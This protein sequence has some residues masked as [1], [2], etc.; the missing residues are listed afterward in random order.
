MSSA[1][2]GKRGCTRAD[3]ASI[4]IFFLL[5]VAVYSRLWANPRNG[6]L[7]NSGMDQML[8]EW[9]FA[10]GADCV[11][12]LRNPLFTYLQNYPYGVNLMAN[13]ATYGL[14]IPLS[15]LTLLFGPTV[16]WTVA[17]TGSLA[18]TA[19]AY[20]WVFSR[21]LVRSRLAAAIGGGFCGFAPAMISH[22][23]GHPNL[24]ALFLIPFIALRL[25]E[26]RHSTHPGRDGAIVGIMMAFQIFL[27]EE[28]LLVAAIFFAVF[29][30][31]YAASQ[32]RD[33]WAFLP[34]LSAGI[35]AAALVTIVLV[36]YPL[37][38]QF[39][40]P[41]S[42]DGL[43]HGLKAAANDV[44]AFVR[45]STESV[46]GDEA[47]AKGFA[48]NVME[49]NA[50]FG[51]PLVA[52]LTVI[53]MWL[54]RTSIFARTLA[55]SGFVMA[56]LS[57]GPRIYIFHYDTHIPGP[58][59]LFATLPLLESLV[60]S[61]LAM[62][63]VP[64]VGALLAM[65]TERVFE[66]TSAQPTRELRALWLGAVAAVLLPIAPTRLQVTERPRPPE[67]F[68]SGTWQQYVEPGG[69]VVV[70]PIPDGDNAYALYWQV[71]TGMR[72]PLVGGYFI[73]PSGPN[74]R[75]GRYDAFPTYTQTQLTSAFESAQVPHVED[76]DRAQVLKDLRNWNAD[77][78]VLAPTKNEQALRSTLEL[79]LNMPAHWV[80]GVWMWDV[81]GLT[82]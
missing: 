60:E 38:W 75:T 16:T 78:I 30:V 72:F 33:A 56:W 79:L 15:P 14:G 82:T 76:G 44:A 8:F 21:H 9:F 53:V 70:A 77:L 52:L 11:R 19:A 58:W 62:A 45:F 61:R 41:Q 66:L 64:A 46:A 6:Y 23:G 51:W 42:Y 31:A 22:G 27:G 57:L 43:I 36:A 29:A 69:A 73:G 28:P 2:A 32:P 13:T 49:E 18:G 55:I 1:I 25:M 20:Y 37:W 67:F 4:L 7:V 34:R 40:G 54:S 26:L 17:L 50:F 59:R 81:R 65:A 47:S 5:A 80:K 35:L 68:S 12:H 3:V 48:L 10:V 39:Y 71:R 24:V 74:D 63:C